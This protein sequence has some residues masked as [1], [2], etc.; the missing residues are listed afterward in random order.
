M[1]QVQFSSSKVT[2]GPGFSI[3][4]DLC[5]WSHPAQSTMAAAASSGTVSPGNI[6]KQ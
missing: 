3:T 5:L 6:Q 4:L 2:E 1:T